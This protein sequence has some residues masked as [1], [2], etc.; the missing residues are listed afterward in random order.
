MRAVVHVYFRNDVFTYSVD[1][2]ILSHV[3]QYRCIIIHTREYL[4][5]W[6]TFIER[7]NYYTKKK[8]SNRLKWTNLEIFVRIRA[9]ITTSNAFAK[10]H[11]SLINVWL[12]EHCG[13]GDLNDSLRKLTN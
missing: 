12:L 11:K 4:E 6:E 5:S 7:I 1:I 3:A 9:L 8:L 2:I 13:A 10:S